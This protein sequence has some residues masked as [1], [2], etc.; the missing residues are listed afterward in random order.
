M[1]EPTS[2][3]AFSTPLNYKKVAAH[4]IFSWTLISRTANGPIKNEEVESYALSHDFSLLIKMRVVWQV[5]S[6]NSG[7]WE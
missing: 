3:A 7:P 6:V 1:P 4:Y 5:D 2:P